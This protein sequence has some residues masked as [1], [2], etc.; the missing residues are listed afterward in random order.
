MTAKKGISEA[1]VQ[2]IVASLQSAG[3]GDVSLAQLRAS[4]AGIP[5]TV[6][7]DDD[8]PV[9]ARPVAEADTFNV[10]LVGSAEHCV[11]LTADH[12]AATGIVIAEKVV[13]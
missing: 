4:H 6:C 11:L 9:N 13:D 8:I 3:L 10:Y 12:G 1:C 5:F 2:A 7:M